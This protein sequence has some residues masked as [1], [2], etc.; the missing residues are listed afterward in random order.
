[1]DNTQ[2]DGHFH[3]VGVGEDNLVLCLTPSGIQAEEIG[4]SIRYSSNDGFIAVW[5]GEIPS[6]AEEVQRLREDI[7][8]DEAGVDGECTHEQNNI[9]T[10][11]MTSVYRYHGNPNMCS[12]EER[13]EDFP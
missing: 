5:F 1:M 8:V 6:G 9:A 11:A 2:N 13:P 3:L 7:I 12:Q 4:V 10:A